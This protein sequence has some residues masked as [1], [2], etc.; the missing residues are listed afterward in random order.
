MASIGKYCKAYLVKSFREFD[1]WT[2]K[3]E[4]A[5]KENK[6]VDGKGQSSARELGPEDH[7]FLQENFVVTDGIFLDENIIYDNIS[8][9]WVE[10]CKHTLQFEIPDYSLE[11]NK[12][13]NAAA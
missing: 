11:S 7:L 9:E 13:N 2:E 1:G 10:F 6:E 3:S 5:R 4:N 12:A 8:P